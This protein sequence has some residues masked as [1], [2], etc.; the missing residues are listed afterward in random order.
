MSSISGIA[1]TT[2][3]NPYLASNANPVA[4]AQNDF[5]ALGTALQSNDPTAAQTALAA[6][7]KD[8]TNNPQAS[9]SQP[10]GKNTQA[11]S[12]FQNLVSAVQSGNTTAAQKAFSSLTTDLKAAHKSH[13]H[14]ASSIPS[15]TPSATNPAGSAVTTVNGG[16]DNAIASLNATA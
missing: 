11:N 8:L 13:H 12:D 5:R 9:A 7:Q 3:V 10:F 2:S 6:F 4:Q 15:A 1:S 14:H 16:S